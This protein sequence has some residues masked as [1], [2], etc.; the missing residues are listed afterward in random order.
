MGIPVLTPGS[1]HFQ[2]QMFPLVSAVTLHHSQVRWGASAELGCLWLPNSFLAFKFGMIPLKCAICR[3][4]NDGFFSVINQ[5][6]IPSGLRWIFHRFHW[7][8]HHV[9]RWYT[10]K[11][12]VFLLRTWWFI[13]G[14]PGYFDVLKSHPH[15]LIPYIHHALNWC[16]IWTGDGIRLNFPMK[17]PIEISL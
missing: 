7:F 11:W 1:P 2:T 5:W 15:T 6:I 14:I 9:L 16:S 4:E 8:F 10:P 17:Y 12:L 13:S 3:R